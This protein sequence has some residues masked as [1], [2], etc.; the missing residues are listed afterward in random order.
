MNN[1][2]PQT[3]TD[4]LQA[5]L[6][7]VRRIQF[8]RGMLGVL[9]CTLAVVL[10][11]MAV[12]YLFSPLSTNVRW[13]LFAIIIA[14]IIVSFWRLFLRPLN[15]RIELL[16]IAR[17]LEI[18]HP[19]MQERISTAM[20]LSNT[21][22]SGTSA[23]LLEELITEAEL[24]VQSLNPEVEVKAKKL[25][26]WL[27]PT[28]A[29]AT[30]FLSL[31]IIWPD[32][33]SRLLVRAVAPFSQTGNAGAIAFEIKPGDLEVLEGDAVDIRILYQGSSNDTLTLVTT[34]SDGSETEEQLAFTGSEDGKHIINYKLAAAQESFRYRVRSGRKES[35]G[36][37]VT[38]WPKPRLTNLESTYD[39]P[40]YTGLAR[41][42]RG[43]DAT[44]IRAIVGTQIQLQAAPNTPVESGVFML[45]DQKICD[46]QIEKNA[47][48]G[49]LTCHFSMDAKRAGTGKIILTHRLGHEI[50]VASFPVQAIPDEAPVVSLLTPVKRELRVRPNDELPITYQVVEQIGLQS[51]KLAIN[52]NGKK[53]PPLSLI[54]PKRAPKN[55][56]HGDASF[57]VG[58]LLD[59][60]PKAREVELRIQIHDN[61]PEAFGGP[62]IGESEKILLRISRSAESLVRQELR[63]QESD[64]RETTREAEKNIREAAARMRQQKEQVKKEELSEHSRKQLEKAREQLAK[65]EKA[66][67][68]LAEK[69]KNGVHAQKAEDVKKAAE[70]AQESREKV[71]TAPVQDS[72]DARKKELEQAEK[73]AEEALEALEKMRRKMDQDREK[74][75]DIA[76]LNEL[77]QKE[78][79]LARQAEQRAAE[80]NQNKQEDREWQQQQ[81][82]IQEELRREVNQRPDAVAEAAK[83]QA[84][85]A[86]ELA[87]QAREL[88]EQQ[89]ELENIARQAEKKDNQQG[90][91]DAIREQLKKAQQDLVD[92]AKE[93]LD[94]AH[95]QQE[96]RANELPEAVENA[97]KAL[98]EIGEKNDAKAAEAAREAAKQL[99]QAAQAPNQQEQG[100][101]Q[102]NQ[103]GEQQGEQQEAQNGEQQEQGNQQADEQLEKLADQQEKVA[104]ALDALDKGQTDKAQE[105]LQQLQAD[106][107]KQLAE[108]VEAIPEIQG[109][110]GE[111][112]QAEQAAK[113][114][115]NHAQEAAQQAEQGN[116]QAAA[117]RNQQAAQ[118]LNKAAQALD[119][120]AK[121]LDAQ[122]QQAAAKANSE[123]AKQAQ[124]HQAPVDGKQL[125]DAFQ[126]SAEAAQAQSPQQ[127]SEAAREAA[128][129][130][131]QLAQQAMQN[132]QQ[133]K[134]P[135]QQPG[136][137]GQQPGQQ[138]AQN[139]PSNQTGDKPKE[140]MRIPE[141]DPGVP[142]ELAKLGVSMKDW[143]KL[144]EMMRSDVAGSG[145][146]DVPEDYRNLVRRYFEQIANEGKKT[147]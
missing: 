12:D 109:K 65:A 23:G 122:A 129:A 103:Q 96:Q 71:E 88:G 130:L 92:Q 114:G 2:F 112:A 13:G 45:G 99:D 35:D 113:Q 93:Q 82:E 117:Q 42:K 147:P 139:E 49:R 138:T 53:V 22:D 28:C 76:R 79:E 40:E 19:E 5:V 106:A 87:E 1:N 83:Q 97:E 133:G 51:A 10:L 125:A 47:S 118:A 68:E 25:K 143:E 91:E 119:A 134:Q 74:V 26:T 140:G 36:Y 38:V 84:E 72:P 32:Q 128:D 55:Q 121:N 110:S 41:S 62:Y 52:V 54:L 29:L 39:Y 11:I 61:C 132:M 89:K 37:Q 44:G 144:K 137:N 67:E 18:R 131:N 50:E 66:L 60:Y 77:A 7:R 142:P 57:S 107:A 86:R 135:G 108:D 14:T 9:T 81:R 48:G 95:Q 17:W 124:Q 3:I 56:W 75:E 98:D 34:R 94:Q 8:F 46:V 90:L 31:F 126:K 69:M 73:A 27:W 123:Q 85:Q 59:Q 120:Q 104:E 63:A 70:K 105:A 15:R 78:R 43:I 20:E 145:N 102:Q 146:T 21:S 116:Q 141:P 24:D 80:A 127:A 30:I 115:E 100:N 6:R 58:A 33:V 111:M 4:R 16:Q 64:I 101:Q 136:K